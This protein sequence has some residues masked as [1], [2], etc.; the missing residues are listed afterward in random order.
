MRPFQALKND[1]EPQNFEIFDKVVNNFGKF[2]EVI[3]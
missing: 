3:I 2:D 1:F